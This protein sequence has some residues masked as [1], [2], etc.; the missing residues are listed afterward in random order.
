[1]VAVSRRRYSSVVAASGSTPTTRHWSPLPCRIRPS[2]G[3]FVSGRFCR[4]CSTSPARPYGEHAAVA[5]FDNLSVDADISQQHVLAE[6][7]AGHMRALSVGRSDLIR[8]INLD[9]PTTSPAMRTVQRAIGDHYHPAQL[10][11]LSQTLKIN[12]APRTSMDQAHHRNEN[13]DQRP[14]RPT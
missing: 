12:G 13:S 4:L 3:R 11:V 10:S 14:Q 8:V 1:M 7:L 2:R 6:E 5:A 9:L